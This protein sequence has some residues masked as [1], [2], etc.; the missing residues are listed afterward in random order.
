MS[1]SGLTKEGFETNKDLETWMDT[2]YGNDTRSGIRIEIQALRLAMCKFAYELTNNTKYRDK[3]LDLKS[4]VKEKFWNG[5]IL[6]DGL[7]DFTIRPNIFIAAHVYQELLTKKEWEKCFQNSLTSLWLDWGGLA[8][9]D[10]KNYLFCDYHTGENNKSYHRG[11]S[12]FWINNLAALV[13]YRTNK[14]KFKKF[15]DKIL[16]ASTNEILWKGAL[17]NHSELSSANKLTSQG[18]LAQ[19]WSNAMYIELINCIYL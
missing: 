3:E 13:L 9:I 4:N 11:D 8:T 5:K 10:K 17:G 7:N 19:S 6:A 15:I 1:E 14:N 18:C 12:W 2:Y 16:E